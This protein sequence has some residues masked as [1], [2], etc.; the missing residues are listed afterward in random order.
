[1]TSAM[2]VSRVGPCRVERALATAPVPRPPQPTSAMFTTPDSPACTC[3]NTMPA[4]ADAAAT[5]PVVFIM[6][7]RERPFFLSGLRKTPYVWKKGIAPADT[8][9]N[10]GVEGIPHLGAREGFAQ[11]KSGDVGCSRCSRVRQERG[12]AAETRLLGE[13]G[14]TPA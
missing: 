14:Y 10:L 7:R 8:P 12:R 11:G 13:G 2:A 6:S 3:G 9:A 4:S 1:K 5:F